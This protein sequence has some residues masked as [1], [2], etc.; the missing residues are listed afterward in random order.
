MT[1][2][3][4]LIDEVAG[5]ELEGSLLRLARSEGPSADGRRKILAGIAAVLCDCG[6][7]GAGPIL[8]T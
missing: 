3:T 5:D 2:P 4:R 7:A 8:R 1:D 6:C